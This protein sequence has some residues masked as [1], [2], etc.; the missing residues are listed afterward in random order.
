MPSSIH[1]MLHQSLLTLTFSPKLQRKG[2]KLNAPLARVKVWIS[3]GFAIVGN[4]W[5]KVC[6]NYIT[7]KLQMNKIHN[8]SAVIFRH[9]NA[10]IWHISLNK[11]IFGLL[12]DDSHYCLMTRH[13]TGNGQRKSF[14]I[15]K[16][17]MDGEWK[18]GWSE[19]EE[20]ERQE[21]FFFT[22]R[23]VFYKRNERR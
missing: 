4:I 18:R 17:R 20:L 11:N 16:T 12:N 8:K 19:K 23:L 15:K 7:N 6:T 3:L 13:Q 21:I 1:I 5:T 10:K 2:P 14:S 22:P 9:F